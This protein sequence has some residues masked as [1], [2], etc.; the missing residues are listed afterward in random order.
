MYEC[1]RRNW[2]DPIALLRKVVI[3]D[4]VSY[5]EFIL[6]WCKKK[7]VKAYSFLSLEIAYRAVVGLCSLFF[8]VKTGEIVFDITSD[9][10]GIVLTVS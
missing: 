9:R 5:L 2:A 3:S 4:V 10:S 6:K 8:G 1:G 7:E